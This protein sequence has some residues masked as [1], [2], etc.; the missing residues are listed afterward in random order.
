[1]LLRSNLSDFT[2]RYF[3]RV[4]AVEMTSYDLSYFLMLVSSGIAW[5][6]RIILSRPIDRSGILNYRSTVILP[7]QV[8]FNRNFSFF[9]HQTY[10]LGTRW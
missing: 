7:S 10:C 1:M 6:D 5:L 2:T 8:I 4:S 3:R 9:L